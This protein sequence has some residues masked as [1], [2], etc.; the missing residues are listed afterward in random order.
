MKNILN[1]FLV[2]LLLV[3]DSAQTAFANVCFVRVEKASS[4]TKE[5]PDIERALYMLERVRSQST[6]LT[7]ENAK[8]DH[9][10]LALA[11]TGIE[12]TTPKGEVLA[13]TNGNLVAKVLEKLGI[14]KEV[15]NQLIAAS[16]LTDQVQDGNVF[17]LD[18]DTNTGVYRL[19]PTVQGSSSSKLPKE[20]IPR[21]HFSG[22]KKIM[23]A[24]SNHMSVNSLDYLLEL[25]RQDETIRNI[26][27][28]NLFSDS[29][30][31]A[32]K[33]WRGQWD[34]KQSY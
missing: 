16:F 4:E 7:A 1:I 28:D 12:I 26:F 30:L 31:S 17:Y 10:M 22:L 19:N 13:D 34:H 2:V 23:D 20:I 29:E 15:R 14:V 25:I 6:G 8:T 3:C 32:M 9:N 21:D 24:L 33:S 27:R 11:L 18:V 5:I